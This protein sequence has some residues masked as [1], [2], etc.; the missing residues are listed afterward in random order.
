MKSHIHQSCESL[1]L[2]LR[3]S[4]HRLGIEHAVS[5][6]AQPA[7]PLGNQDSS[8]RQKGHTPWLVNPFT[9]VNRI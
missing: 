1:C 4:S 8:I 3:Q 6:N 5:D 7:G 2:D 9:I